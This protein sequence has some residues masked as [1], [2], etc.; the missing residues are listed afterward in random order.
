MGT[1]IK[2]TDGKVVYGFLTTT[3]GE[4]DITGYIHC[5][6]IYESLCK[7]Y[8]TVHLTLID[9]DNLIE[10][11]NLRGGDFVDIGVKSYPNEYV[12]DCRV[13]VL[14]MEGH[15]A[16]T[17]LKTQIYEVDLVGK[18]YF[19][20]KANIVQKSYTEQGTSVIS[21]IWGQYLAP[22]GDNLAIHRQSDGM[23]GKQEEKAQTDHKKPFA[24][25][26]EIRQYLKFGGKSSPTVLF[27]DNQM[28]NLAPLADLF[29][30][31]NMY[32]YIQKE[33]WGETWF[34]PDIYRGIIVAQAEIDQNFSGE[35]SGGAGGTGAI[36]K[37]ISQGQ[38]VFDLFKGVPA[39]FA[40]AARMASGNFGAGI[41]GAASGLSS[42]IG[43]IAGGL[44]GSPNIQY[45]NSN[46]WERENAPDTKAMGEQSYAAEVKNGPQLKIKVPLQ[47]G[48]FATVGKSITA[49][50]LPPVGDF[51][52]NIHSYSLS[53][54]WLVKDLVHELYTDNRD[55]KGTT[56]MQLI[57]GGSGT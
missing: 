5:V 17:N 30:K 22:G 41:A 42:A 8:L 20:D 14:N 39:K 1:F 6:R 48:F 31:N 29:G 46:R 53:G 45:T 13:H 11:S 25:I 49:F 23:L 51:P 44:G 3:R 35:G 33:T 40:D 28:A 34:D 43:S 56:T 12:Y 19:N 27:R 54:L 15:Q 52:G 38:G 57:R 16:T 36:A 55:V 21:A 32:D 24:A 9:N 7:P 37:A 50:L 26:D 2:P 47:T 18:A 4:Y 10:S